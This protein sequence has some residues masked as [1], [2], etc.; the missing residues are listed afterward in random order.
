MVEQGLAVPVRAAVANDLFVRLRHFGI[1]LLFP[2]VEG[3]HLLGVPGGVYF[4]T[5]GAAANLSGGPAHKELARADAHRQV[6]KHMV[7]R[8]GPAVLD[9]RALGTAEG[10]GGIQSLFHTDLGLHQ[11]VLP[12]HLDP[13]PAGWGQYYV[14]SDSPFAI[15]WHAPNVVLSGAPGNAPGAPERLDYS[16]SLRLMISSWVSGPSSTKKAE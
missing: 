11:H 16:S 15:G 7:Q 5:Q 2:G 12:Q 6:S 4:G 1:V 8:P 10:F 14:H 3:I 9:G 13:F